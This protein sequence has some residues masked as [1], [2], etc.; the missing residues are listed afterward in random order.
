M[1]A[2]CPGLKGS[3]RCRGRTITGRAA[4]RHCGC[5]CTRGAHGQAAM[6]T[7]DQPTTPSKPVHPGWSG[8]PRLVSS[9][10]PPA[11]AP[12]AR[13]WCAGTHLGT[14]A[15]SRAISDPMPGTSGSGSGR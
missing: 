7:A 4:C 8:H 1:G 13:S 14:D 2:M 3:G 5:D 11:P 9:P 6:T 10:P 15:R 12:P